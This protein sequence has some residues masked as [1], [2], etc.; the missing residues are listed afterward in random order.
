VRS[1]RSAQRYAQIW[2][3]DGSPLRAHTERQARIEDIV[4]RDRCP[5]LFDGLVAKVDQ[6]RGLDLGGDRDRDHAHV[7]TVGTRDLHQGLVV[8]VRQHL[9]LAVGKALPAL[10]ALK[11]PGLPAEDVEHVVHAISLPPIPGRQTRQI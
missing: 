6:R 3:T 2:T 8:L 9:E 11:A 10:G 4:R 7:L 5:E 1:P